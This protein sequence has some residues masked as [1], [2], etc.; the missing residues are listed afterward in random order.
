MRIT[1]CVDDAGKSH[2]RG[3]ERGADHAPAHFR[4]R[5]ASEG[6]GS[7][8]FGA[9]HAGALAVVQ[10]L[11]VSGLIFSVALRQF[12]AS[13]L[14]LSDLV[15]SAVLVAALVGFLLIAGTASGGG[16]AHEAADRILQLSRARHPGV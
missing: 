3:D 12:S 5:L 9:L 15:W 7:D 14:R 11:L 8:L 1:S 4:R 10:P 6:D 13:R 2:G 16:Q